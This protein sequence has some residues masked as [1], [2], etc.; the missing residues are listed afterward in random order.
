MT[1]TK[2]IDTLKSFFEEL[3]NFYE[4]SHQEFIWTWDQINEQN[5]WKKKNV[6]QDFVYYIAYNLSKNVIHGPLPSHLHTRMIFGPNNDWS[7][8]YIEYLE[9]K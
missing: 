4:Q 3:K 6:V 5:I 7:K 2:D 1:E 9:G 8:K